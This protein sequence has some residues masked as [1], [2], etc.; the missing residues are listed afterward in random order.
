MVLA[1]SGWPDVFHEL[2]TC[3]KYVLVLRGEIQCAE[4]F[5]NGI[6]ALDNANLFYLFFFFLK[7]LRNSH[8]A[9]INIKGTNTQQSSFPLQQGHT[10]QYEIC[11]IHSC[12]QVLQ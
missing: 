1:P 7:H 11:F 9:G 5:L 3:R 10:V 12:V 8:N 2:R 6:K 4:I